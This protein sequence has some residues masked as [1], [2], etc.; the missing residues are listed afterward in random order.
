MNERPFDILLIDD[1]EDYALTLGERLELR[2]LE[3]RVALSGEQGLEM[4]AE[5][6]PS[7]VLLDMRMPG[8][9]GVEVLE[10]IRQIAPD[11][12]VIIITGYC[13]EGDFVRA[14]SLGV[15]GYLTKPL[16]FEELL[17][18]IEKCREGGCSALPLAAG[19]IC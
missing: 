17:Q 15:Q 13:S 9:S 16:N 6:R 3:T 1:E 12:T 5:R 11:Q 14:Q 19:P 7:L 18:A 2:D 10:R 4:L 8:L